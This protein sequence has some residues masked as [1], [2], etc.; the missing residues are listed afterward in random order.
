MWRMKKCLV[1]HSLFSPIFHISSTFSGYNR[2]TGCIEMGE[3]ERCLGVDIA[4]MVIN[5]QFC[6]VKKDTIT[7]VCKPEN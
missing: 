5:R 6:G 2:I 1:D 3:F 7:D 4:A